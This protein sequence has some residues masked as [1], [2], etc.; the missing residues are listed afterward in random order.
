MV[1]KED[2]DEGKENPKQHGLTG[3]CRLCASYQVF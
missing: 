2:S 1:E 3:N